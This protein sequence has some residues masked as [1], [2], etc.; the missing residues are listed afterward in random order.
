[1]CFDRCEPACV[2]TCP[3]GA[4]V[5]GERATIIQKAKERKVELN[6]YIYGD[7]DNKPLGGT[8]FIYVLKKEPSFYGIPKNVPENIAPEVSVLKNSK[9]LLIPAALGGL[10]Y[11]AS[12]RQ[13]RLK[14]KEE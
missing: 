11:L 12:W 13:R 14:E 5:Y 4:L 8:S 7:V 2:Q 1:M 3:T 6:G 9:L 10:A